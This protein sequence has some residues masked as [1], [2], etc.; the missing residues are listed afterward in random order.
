[1]VARM[2]NK[3]KRKLKV[4]SN[5]KDVLHGL[6]MNW[7]NLKRSKSSQPKTNSEFDYD[8]PTPQEEMDLCLRKIEDRTEHLEENNPDLQKCLQYVHHKISQTQSLK[9]TNVMLRRTNFDIMTDR[10]RSYLER[11]EI[12]SQD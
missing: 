4:K 5:S 9:D 7:L 8:G 12:Y 1:M 10:E 3:S 6:K 11:D 2:R